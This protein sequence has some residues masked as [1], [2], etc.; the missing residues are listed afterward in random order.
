MK[1]ITIVFVAMLMLL[2]IIAGAF[3]EEAITSDVATAEPS[4]TDT[5]DAAA[6]EPDTTDVSAESSDAAIETSDVEAVVEDGLTEVASEET[7]E[8]GTTPD[9]PLWGIERA[10]ERI[11]LAL[12]FDRAKKAEK[13]LLHARERLLEV[14]AMA[15]KGKLKHAAKAAEA[16]AEEVEDAEKELGEAVS[17]DGET[18][19]LKTLEARFDKH[20]QVLE[21]VQAK[22]QE[23]G[24]EAPGIANALAIAK[25]KKNIFLARQA[26]KEAKESGEGLEDAKAGL[27]DAKEGF[28]GT[29]E[30]I[31]ESK[32][33]VK[34]AAEESSSEESTTETSEETSTETEDTSTETTTETS[35][36]TTQ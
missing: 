36:T 34:K 21:R 20:V 19:K 15:K 18:D 28:K 24:I 25:A 32:R 27:E 30:E 6:T 29:R 11:N 31:R 1:K 14:Q 23:K 12:T 10:L 3:A 7:V 26:V 13:R 5:T 35:E 2:S 16:H 17:K 22:L 9:S 8:A 4:T 33:L